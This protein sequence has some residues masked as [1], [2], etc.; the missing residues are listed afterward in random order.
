MK[1]RSA[2]DILRYLSHELRSERT[3]TCDIFS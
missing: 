1:R 2:T 3:I